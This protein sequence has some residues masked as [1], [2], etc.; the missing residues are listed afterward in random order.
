MNLEVYFEQSKV[1]M[2]TPEINLSACEGADW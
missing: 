2:N 1:K